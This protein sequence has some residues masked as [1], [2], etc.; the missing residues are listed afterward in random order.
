M[1]DIQEKP[2]KRAKWLRV[3]RTVSFCMLVLILFFLVFMI[4]YIAGIENWQKLD[5]NVLENMDQTL[6]VYDGEG[7]LCAG[8]HGIINR[9][10]I[11]LEKVPD[12]VRKA[13]ISAE[14][15]RFYEHGG[16]D[17]RRIFGALWADVRSGRIKEGASTITQQLRS[18]SRT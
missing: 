13:F 7:T 1:S 10:D 15:A 17:I 16:V 4:S 3:L 12:H 11:P 5:I 9:I 14:D 6:L 8:V 2:K 18:S